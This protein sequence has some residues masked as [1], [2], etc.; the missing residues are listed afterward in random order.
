MSVANV[1]EQ[2]ELQTFA[3]RL[4]PR[5]QITI[6]Q[7]VREQMAVDEGDVLTLV[8]A[9]DLVFLSRTRPQVPKLADRIAILMDE[10][11]VSLADLLAGL[12][13]ER[14]AIW[15]ERHR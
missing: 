11:G 8:D 2:P 4:R 5:G 12:E 6:P 14:Q 10:A 3:V 1:M 15:N 13:E 7:A 9:G